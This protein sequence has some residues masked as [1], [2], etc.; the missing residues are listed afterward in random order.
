MGESKKKI[1]SGKNTTIK[2]GSAKGKRI[3]EEKRSGPVKKGVKE[4]PQ[5][6]G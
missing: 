5:G 1:P 2:N 4:F 6:L 3:G